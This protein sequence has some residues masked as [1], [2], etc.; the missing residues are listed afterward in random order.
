[1]LRPDDATNNAFVYCLGEAA[2]RFGMQ[3]IL[4]Q[5]ESNHHHTS[6]YDPHGNHPEFRAHFHKLMAKCQNALRGRWENLWAAEEPCTF[7]VVTEDDL[8]DKLVYIATNPVKDG[9]VEKVHHW[10]GPNFVRALLRGI[11]M[12][13]TRPKHFFREHGT[14]PS[15]IELV[16]GLPD[17]FERKEVFLAELERRIRASEESC[18]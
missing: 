6:V 16:L 12:K 17:H 11:V 4:S 1:M 7:E 13:A 3:V 15:E 9:L 10:P 8:L 2:R 18:P 14:I 5:M